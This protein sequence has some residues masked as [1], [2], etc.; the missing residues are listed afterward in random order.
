LHRDALAARAAPR[1]AVRLAAVAHIR[2]RYTDYD[3]LLD[4]GY[5]TEAAR[6]FTADA[7]DAVLEEWGSKRRVA[8]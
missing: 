2:H 1:P 5:G 8:T 7:I 3:R 6:H 4:D